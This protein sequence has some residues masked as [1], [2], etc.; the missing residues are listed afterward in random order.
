MLT[1]VGKIL[2]MVALIAIGGVGLFIFRDHFSAQMQLKQQ[3]KRMREQ[4][5][6]INRLTSDN[7]VAEVIVTDQR[8][9]DGV[10]ETSLLF[11]EY[12]PDGREL[13]PKVLKVKGKIAHVDALVIKF[14]QEHVKVND[15]LRGKSIA[16]FYRVFGDQEK[17]ADAPRI[18]EPGRIPDY[19]R[20]VDPQVSEFEQ[21][22]W[23]K[24]WQLVDDE[25]L[26]KE[27]G[28]RVAQGDGPWGPFEIGKLYTIT[29]DTNGGLNIRSETPKGVYREVL[30]R[31][32]G[33]ATPATT[34]Q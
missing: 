18:D 14:D 26:R 32:A 2:S 8:V 17:P 19:Y 28:V 34:I 20:G 6:V 21:R 30:Q 4:D 11:V 1:S 12:T 7:R 5:A 24:F 10:T 29:L 31:R 3:E 27:E 9:V 22:L 25:N 23:G 15:K 13:L 16:L 33:L